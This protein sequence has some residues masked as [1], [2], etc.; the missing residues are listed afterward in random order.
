[1]SDFQ[2]LK[3]MVAKLRSKDR[4]AND[5]R[6]LSGH[7]S[8]ARLA[9]VLTEI[10]ETILPRRLIFRWDDGPGIQLAVANRR[11]QGILLPSADALEPLAGQ[12]LSDPDDELATKMKAALLATLS[13]AEG[14]SIRAVHLG[15]DDLGSDA[16]IAAEAL[17]RHWGLADTGSSDDAPSETLPDFAAGLKSK[18][19]AWLRVEGEDVADQSGSKADVARLGETAAYL[20]DAY[21]NGKDAL[22]GAEEGPKA[23][24]VSGPEEGLFFADTGSQTIF[25]LTK[26]ENLIDVAGAWRASFG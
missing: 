9:S 19:V 18:A 20:L 6:T 10:N 5:R 13:D 21:L 1:M 17:G 23:F 2:R 4:A 11:L 22:F 12:P 14:A 25:V 3:E 26:P 24:A 15:D 16:G 7:D 8:E